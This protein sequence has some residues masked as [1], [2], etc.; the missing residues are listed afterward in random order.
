MARV[1]PT[2]A[3]FNHIRIDDVGEPDRHDLQLRGSVAR[4]RS[5]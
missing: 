2:F 1:N 3:K 5:H 4:E